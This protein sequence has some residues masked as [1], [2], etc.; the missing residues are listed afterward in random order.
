MINQTDLKYFVEVAKSLHLTRAAERLGVTQPA[1]SHCLKR[2]EAETKTVLFIRSKKGVSLT[3]SG[4]RLADQA[5]ELIEKWNAVVLAAQNEVQE[6]SG[7]IRFGCHTA[8]AQYTLSHFVPNFLQKYPAINLQF[9]HALSR[10]LAEDV[11]SQK[12]DAAFVVNPIAHPDLIIKEISKDR[13]TLWRAKNCVNTDVL[14]VEPS[15]LQT[16]DLLRKL[17]KKGIRFTRI[18]ESSSLEVISQLV[19]SGAGCGILP[20]RVIRALS[21]QNIITIKEAPEFHDRM[22]LIYK[23][24]FRKSMRGQALIQAIVQ[25]LTS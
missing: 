3:R 24:E 15:L 7:T 23:S 11:I 1:L 22:C 8:V 18:I 13:V 10:H 20:E 19:I 2:L 21:D 5:I 6:V 25:S 17:Q 9:S 4:Q 14:I 16:Q 12:L